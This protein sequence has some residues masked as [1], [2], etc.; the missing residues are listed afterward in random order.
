[1][2]KSLTLSLKKMMMEALNRK[3][4]LS[5][6]NN[7]LM[8]HR[9]NKFRGKPALWNFLKDIAQNLRRTKQGF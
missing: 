7:I 4:V 8:A 5:F 3:Y 9:N 6:C 1:M 2:L